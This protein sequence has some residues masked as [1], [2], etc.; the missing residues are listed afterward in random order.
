MSAPV[1]AVTVGKLLTTATIESGTCR[2]LS[3][4]GT[5]DP[6]PMLFASANALVAI[7]GSGATALP[8]GAFRVTCAETRCGGPR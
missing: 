3:V 8:A 4:A 2:P 5:T 1:L 7:A 6:V